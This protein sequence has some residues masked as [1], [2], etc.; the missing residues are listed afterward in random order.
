MIITI[1]SVRT[2]MLQQVTIMLPYRIQWLAMF[3][4]WELQQTSFSGLQHNR[5]V[6][7][8]SLKAFRELCSKTLSVC[9]S[10]FLK[11]SS[12]YA[13]GCIYY[14]QVLNILQF[15]KFS[16]ILEWQKLCS[17]RHESQISH[18]RENQYVLLNQV[19]RHLE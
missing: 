14:C 11:K 15:I 8:F 16:K 9:C 6:L 13:L 2:A 4:Q 1:T 5:V 17:I 10:K 7:E 18:N 3:L 19:I 12:Q